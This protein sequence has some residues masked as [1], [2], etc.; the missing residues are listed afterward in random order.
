MQPIRQMQRKIGD[1]ILKTCTL[2]SLYTATIS[3]S[4]KR[5]QAIEMLKRA[6]LGD[7]IDGFFYFEKI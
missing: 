3:T 4:V 1:A 5:M 7:K 6:I 2:C